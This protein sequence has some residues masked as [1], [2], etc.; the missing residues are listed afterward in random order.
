MF[1]STLDLGSLLR[2]ESLPSESSF[3]LNEYSEGQK[4]ELTQN[5]LQAAETELPN[6]QEATKTSKE[7]TSDSA[8]QL[9]LMLCQ[10]DWE[11]SEAMR[12]IEDIDQF[13][14]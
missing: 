14:N 7:K 3:G 9:S 10:D 5:N 11:S 13:L 6:N 2:C 12:K 8:C 4:D 1:L